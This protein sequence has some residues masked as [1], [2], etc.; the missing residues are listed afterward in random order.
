MSAKLTEA[1]IDVL[2]I[3]CA[4]G[5]RIDNHGSL[6]GCWEEEPEPCECMVPFTDLLAERVARLVADRVAQ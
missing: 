1:E 6:A 2:L 4:C 5:H 3:P